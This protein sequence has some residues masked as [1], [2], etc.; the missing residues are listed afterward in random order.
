MLIS[1][2]ISILEDFGSL[3]PACTVTVNTRIRSLFIFHYYAGEVYDDEWDKSY[4]GFKTETTNE[5][6]KKN[7]L[8]FIEMAS[9][10]EE[11]EEK[12]EYVFAEWNE[13]HDED[14]G[15]Y[16]S[17]RQRWLKSVKK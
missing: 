16:L 14:E 12:T 2:V 11:I 10:R 13:E 6:F 1:A 15:D 7:Y 17:D 8:R 5:I 4:R 9:L 3:L